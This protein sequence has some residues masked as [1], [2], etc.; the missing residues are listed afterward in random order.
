M[1]LAI[2]NWQGRVS[3][4]FDEARSVLL[5][6]IQNCQVVARN[7]KS[8]ISN[9][10]LER[11]RMI[12]DEK[13]DVL[14]CGAISFVLKISMLA[15]GVQVIDNICG[16]IDQVLTAFLNNKLSDPLYIMP[17][18]NQRCR[19]RNRKRKGHNRERRFN[20]FPI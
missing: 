4:V 10:P 18:C 20:Q 19:R 17:G 11:S 8:I 1:R 5:I 9:D 6:D 15:T 16:P 7:E 13:V 2:P 3:V 14:I 12:A